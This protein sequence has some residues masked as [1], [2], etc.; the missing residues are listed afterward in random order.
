[1]RK[2]S[3]LLLFLLSLPLLGWAQQ[4][5]HYSQYMLNPLLLNPAV[6]GT[7][8]YLDVRAGYRNQWTGLEGAP[9]SY[10]LSA[11]MPLSRMDYLSP[12]TTFAPRPAVKGKRRNQ[13]RPEFRNNAQKTRPHHGVGLLVQADKAAG[14]KRTEVQLLYAY[15]Q[16][17][18]PSIKLAAGVAAGLTQFGLNRDLL[19]F[20]NPGDP[21]M[22]ADEYNR[23]LPNIGVGVLLYSNRFFLGASVAQVLPT[24]FTFRDSRP[25]VL[26]KQQR[27]FFGHGGYRFQLTNIVSVMPSVVVKYAAPNPVSV[28]AN[29]KVFWREQFWVGG[30]YRF[31]D[32]AVVTAGFQYKHKFHLGYAYDLTT[33][34]LNQASYGS[35]ELVLGLML[36]NRRSVYSPS[37]YW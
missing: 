23:V 13:W 32:A 15:H 6:S 5:P 2:N 1:M 17:L 36:R 9:T 11:H 21:V 30:S 8:N 3:Y 10:Y 37:Q 33:S 4:I 7:D 18:T 29:V 16:P 19:T 22:N 28:D 20:A 26:A 27:H 31:Q 34:G 35:H 24:P 25:G 12:P 14:L